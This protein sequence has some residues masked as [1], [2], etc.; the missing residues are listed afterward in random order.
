[1]V[2][3]REKNNKKYVVITNYTETKL[4][5]YSSS[6]VLQFTCIKECYIS[7]L[8]ELALPPCLAELALPPCSVDPSNLI[9]K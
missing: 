4:S 6:L 7:C 5:T 3:N 2:I 8:A 1:M 9:G